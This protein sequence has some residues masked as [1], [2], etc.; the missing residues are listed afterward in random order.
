MKQLASLLLLCVCAVSVSA[1]PL[2]AEQNGDH[3]KRYV[4]TVDG[5]NCWAK[6]A[7]PESAP[8]QCKSVPIIPPTGAT[9][10]PIGDQ[11]LV[12][13][14][15][16][17][18]ALCYYHLVTDRWVMANDV[19]ARKGFSVVAWSVLAAYFLLMEIGRAHV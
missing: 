5:T 3:K 13:K 17:G 14:D 2:A 15:A 19:K 12:L 11:H 18:K 8:Y 6:T 7:Q 4:V 16:G 1:A 10:E 9:L